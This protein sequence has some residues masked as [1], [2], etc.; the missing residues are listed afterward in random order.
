[1]VKMVEVLKQTHAKAAV[2]VGA[3]SL[4]LEKSSI[5]RQHLLLIE[6]ELREAAVLAQTLISDDPARR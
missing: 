4:A 6:R 2:A 5:T 1:M 3:I